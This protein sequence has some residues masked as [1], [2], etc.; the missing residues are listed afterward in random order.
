MS[1]SEWESLCDGCGRCCV[2][3]IVQ[4]ETGEVRS[5]NV[6][7]RLL[8]T[9][10]CRCMDYANRKRHVPECISLR[11]ALVAEFDWLPSTCAYRLIHEGRD[12]P[13]WHPLVSGDPESVHRA[14]ISVR[15]HVVSARDVD[16]RERPPATFRR[17]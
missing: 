2:E 4:P 13:R 12:L 8:D 15:G 5:T 14:G 9:E 11:P 3:Q 10:S 7:C 1:R 6:A 16:R 17:R